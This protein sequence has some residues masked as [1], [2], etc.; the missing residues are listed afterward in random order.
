M[1]LE[2]LEDVVA[3]GLANFRDVGRALA[4]IRAR[5][6]YR[7]TDTTWAAYCRRRWGFTDRHADR[8]ITSSKVVLRLQAGRQDGQDSR[9][10]GP[11]RLLP[12]PEPANESQA[13][14]LARVPAPLRERV[15]AHL[16]QTGR[17]TA[18]RIRAVRQS[19][20]GMTT[21]EK[22][23]AAG[24][25]EQQALVRLA[26]LEEETAREKILRLCRRL[27]QLHGRLPD[28][29]AADAALKAYLQAALGQL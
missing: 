4:Q 23:A 24:Q 19:I 8:L 27:G 13:R 20:E 9:P 22:L 26:D 28:P 12:P 7:E 1:N 5:R 15:I 10:I 16:R 18:E 21:D 3:T 14:E 11:G 2:D 25:A 6:L 17:Q 29:P